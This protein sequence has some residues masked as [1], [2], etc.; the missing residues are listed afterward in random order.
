MRST[1]PAPSHPGCPVWCALHLLD[2]D[3]DGLVHLSDTQPVVD[4]VVVTGG[5]SDGAVGWVDLGVAG[6]VVELS[7]A[8]AVAVAGRLLQL[9]GGVLR[10]PGDMD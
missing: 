5:V 2:P 7:P 3:G 9:V 1:R 10:V 8:E 6:R 4:Q